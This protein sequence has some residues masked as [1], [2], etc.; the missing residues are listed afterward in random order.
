MEESREEETLS[1]R[2]K[3]PSQGRRSKEVPRS[4]GAHLR[5]ILN[6]WGGGKERSK[7]RI[8]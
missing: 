7:F 5:A 3:K 4:L 8:E 6:L 1:P 2:G